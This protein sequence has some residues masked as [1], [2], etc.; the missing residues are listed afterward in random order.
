MHHFIK[1]TLDLLLLFYG[2]ESLANLAKRPELLHDMH[3]IFSLYFYA[4]WHLMSVKEKKLMMWLWLAIMSTYET[5][6][7]KL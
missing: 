4:N 5:I 1:L 7:F 6:C 3:F 2:A